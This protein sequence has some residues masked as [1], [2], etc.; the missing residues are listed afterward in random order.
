MNCTACHTLIPEASPA[1]PGCGA[2]QVTASQQLPAGTVLASGA[3]RIDSVVG[4]GGFAI[5]YLAHDSVLDRRVA[6][7]EFF[8][9]GCVRQGRDVRPS[10]AL[11]EYDDCRRR[12][13]DEARTLARFNHPAIVAVY[14][15][16]EENNTAYMAMEYVQAWNVSDWM[17]HRGP[18]NEADTLAVLGPVCEALAVVHEAG[19]LHR[20]IKPENILRTESGRVVLIDFGTAREYVAARTRRLTGIL[21]PAYAPLEQYT[22]RGQRGPATDIYALGATVYHM[23]TGA[24]PIEA[25]ERA[26]GVRLPPL[27]EV[28]PSISQ[29]LSDAVAQ[30]MAMEAD[31]RFQS[32]RAFLHSL[33]GE[34]PAPAPVPTPPPPPA[35]PAALRRATARLKLCGHRAAVR[36]VALRRDGELAATGSEDRTVRLWSTADGLEV[37][38]LDGHTGWVSAVAFDPRG[39]RLASGSHDRSAIVWDA[40]S[41]ERLAKVK[42]TDAVLSL[43]WTADGGRLALGLQSRKVRI[44]EPHDAADRTF[45][46]LCGP[47]LAVSFSPDSQWLAAAVSAESGVYVRDP[48]GATLIW[49]GHTRSV[50]AVAFSPTAPMLASGGADGVVRLWSV[51]D[52]LCRQAF[53]GHGKAVA[54]LAWSRTGDW[55]MVARKEQ[56]VDVFDVSR[57]RLAYSFQAHAR[58]LTSIAATDD[59]TVLTGSVDETAVL[60]A[61]T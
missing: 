27:R 5:T 23:M 47:V 50:R 46:E 57:G 16:F 37:H 8:P 24:P 53:D 7:K 22:S 11:G 4:Q 40:S 52:G 43:A 33:D 14:G 2:S 26:S 29:G 28:V 41:G 56:M 32:I 6:L 61:L 35:A 18:F 59:T 20:D 15:L 25:T 19:W 10:T 3:Y 9:F 13:L 1:C 42:E 54:A 30:A 17:A 60:W 58:E 34:V 45:W 12:F 48:S 49:A 38:R 55:L 31:E 36:A 51:P 39:D 21:T 44:W